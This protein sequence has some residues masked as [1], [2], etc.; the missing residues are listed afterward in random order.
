MVNFILQVDSALLSIWKL[1]HYSPQRF[2]VFQKV[3][4]SYGQTPL[5][6]VRAAT[7]RWLS[8]GKACIRFSKRYV[9]ILDALDEIYDLKKEPEVFDL[10]MILT[11]RDVVAMI[12]LLCDVLRPLNFLSLYLQDPHIRFTSVDTRV[13]ATINE[14]TE[15]I[16]LLENLDGTSGV[17]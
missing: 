8:H 4:E 3:Q 12:L 14:L 17:V 5:A 7:T 6:L 1:F 15:L 13:K 2:A 16:P 11:Q 10:R 9:Q